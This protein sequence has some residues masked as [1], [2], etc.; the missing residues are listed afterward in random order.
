MSLHAYV[1]RAA[2]EMHDLSTTD[3]RRRAIRDEL[4]PL[5]VRLRRLLE[6]NEFFWPS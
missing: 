4:R 3:A 2:A 5:Y 1:E 6:G